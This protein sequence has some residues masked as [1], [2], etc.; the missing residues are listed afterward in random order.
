M[1]TLTVNPPG[2]QVSAKNIAAS[3]RQGGPFSPTS[4]SYSL[5]ATSG[6]VKYQQFPVDL[7]QDGFRGAGEA[8]WH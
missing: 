3:G 6:S 8:L 4:F 5:N 2:L 1:A 7:N